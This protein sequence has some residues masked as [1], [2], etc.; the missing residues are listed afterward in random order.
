MNT[1][2]RHL[3]TLFAWVLLVVLAVSVILFLVNHIN[4]KPMTKLQDKLKLIAVIVSGLQ[5]V[6]GFVFYF[7]RGWHK[8]IGEMASAEL[9]FVT[10]EHP[11]TMFIGIILIHIG[12]AKIRRA[13]DDKKNLKG[14]IF[15]GLSL[16]FIL[17]RTPWD[18]LL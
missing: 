5:L 6:L 8:S 3:H 16:L 7:Y 15:F 11:L 10:L 18:K 4:K 12:S 2:L 13:A 1:G 14:L 9:R 17:S